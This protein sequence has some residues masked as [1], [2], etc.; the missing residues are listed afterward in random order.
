MTIFC[1]NIP[2]YPAH[3]RDK[4][5]HLQYLT[6]YLWRSA[7]SIDDTSCWNLQI[8][9]QHQRSIVQHRT[10]GNGWGGHREGE[11]NHQPNHQWHYRVSPTVQQ[12]ETVTISTVREVNLS[13]FSL[14]SFTGTALRR[15]E[16][17]LS[18][19]RLRSRWNTS[20]PTSACPWPRWVHC[21]LSVTFIL[22]SQPQGHYVYL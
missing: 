14:T 13:H 10:A 12:E 21:C 6:I 11:T 20:P 7:L 16:S 4:T 1:V 18:S 2:T 8:W 5:N 3:M 9:W 15:K 22:F 19:I 17:R